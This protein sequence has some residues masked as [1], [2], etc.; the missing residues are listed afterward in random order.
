MSKDED[1]EYGCEACNKGLN[2]DE[3]YSTCC[4]QFCKECYDKYNPSCAV[5]EQ[6]I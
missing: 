5:K 1:K 3:L 4:D 6:K 2:K